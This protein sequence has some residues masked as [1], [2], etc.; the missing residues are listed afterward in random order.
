M[1]AA[2]EQYPSLG[3]PDSFDDFYDGNGKAAGTYTTSDG[4][5]T[6]AKK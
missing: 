1:P 5:K 4:G 2:F 6:W 3:L